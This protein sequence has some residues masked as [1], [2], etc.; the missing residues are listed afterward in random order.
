MTEKTIIRSAEAAKL[1]GVTEGALRQMRS[2]HKVPYYKNRTGARVYYLKSE[3]E[4]W[5]LGTRIATDV[6]IKSRAINEINNL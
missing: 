5:M 6:E 1:L 3:L 2:K 4:E